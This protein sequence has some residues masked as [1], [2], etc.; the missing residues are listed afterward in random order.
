LTWFSYPLF[1]HGF[2]ATYNKAFLTKKHIQNEA[3]RNPNKMRLTLQN[4]A[5]STLISGFLVAFSENKILLY[6]QKFVELEEEKHIFKDFKHENKPFKFQNLRLKN[7]S[8]D[9]VKRL[10]PA[11]YL[12]FEIQANQNINYFEGAILSTAKVVKLKNI[13]DFQFYLD[14]IDNSETEQKIAIL[15]GEIF[16][17][18]NEFEEQKN[19]KKQLENEI[20]EIQS[21]YEKFT[22][23]KKTN[24]LKVLKIKELELENFVVK[25]PGIRAKNNELK[26]LKNSLKKKEITFNVNAILLE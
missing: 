6:D 23:W 5:D 9:S 1:A 14:E 18:M 25:K 26:A 10:F 22:D 13:T 12:S 17:E 16:D 20:Q 11:P 24:S 8:E 2:W 15:E 19:E 21:S 4:R 7:I 3:K